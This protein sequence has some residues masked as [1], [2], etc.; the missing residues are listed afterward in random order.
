MPE[1]ATDLVNDTPALVTEGPAVGTDK[2]PKAVTHASHPIPYT[3]TLALW[4]LLLSRKIRHSE[5]KLHAG[6]AWVNLTWG[7]VSP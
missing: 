2:R 5:P 4:V 1:P 3:Y 6:E 7:K